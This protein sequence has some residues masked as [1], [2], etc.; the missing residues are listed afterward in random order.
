MMAQTLN[1]Q[2]SDELRGDLRKWRSRALPI[3]IAGAVLSAIGFFISPFQFYRSYLWSY[4]FILAL[5]LGPLAWLLLQY[6]TGGAWGMVIRR[7]SEA[8]LRTLPLVA[9]MFL[10][11]VIGIRN[12]Y[13]WSHADRVAASAVLQHK[14]PYLNLP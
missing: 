8:V 6:L 4:L 5:T 14:Q 12:L 11:I 7:P 13:D 9:V 10:P 3:G 1:F 2:V